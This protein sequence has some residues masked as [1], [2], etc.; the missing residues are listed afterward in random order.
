MQKTR[1]PF[2]HIVNG[3]NHCG[4]QWL[5]FSVGYVSALIYQLKCHPA[6]M[7]TVLE[8]R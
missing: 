5:N 6:N 3:G 2:A 7:T 8:Y 1:R 4:N